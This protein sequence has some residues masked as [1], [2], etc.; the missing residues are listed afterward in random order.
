MAVHI[1]ALLPLNGHH[2]QDTMQRNMLEEFYSVVDLSDPDSSALVTLRESKLVR[3][4]EV[5]ALLGGGGSPDI[6]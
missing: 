5:R 4:P 6:W 1:K 3:T 2:S